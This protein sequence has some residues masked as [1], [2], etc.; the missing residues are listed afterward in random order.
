VFKFQIDFPQVQAPSHSSVTGRTIIFHTPRKP[1]IWRS[2]KQTSFCTAYD[3]MPSIYFNLFL[4]R[5][6][7]A[8]ECGKKTKVYVM[9]KKA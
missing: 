7:S 4:L 2:P 1:P 5:F 6:W 3:I 9:E 8:I